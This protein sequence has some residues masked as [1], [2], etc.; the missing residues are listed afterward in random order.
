MVGG[1]GKK[2]YIDIDAIE[3][4]CQIVYTKKNKT[5]NEEEQEE[6][7]EDNIPEINIF[8]YDIVKLC[9]DRV[10]SEYEED[11]DDGGL[12]KFKTK[13]SP[14]SFSIAFNTLIKYNIILEYDD[15]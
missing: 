2:Y 6:Y 13:D 10:L 11:D 9:I 7:V 3:K 5:E 14:I 4:N 1:Y 12:G 15:E 8:K